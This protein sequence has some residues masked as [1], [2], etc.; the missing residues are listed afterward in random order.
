MFQLLT[1]GKHFQLG[2]VLIGLNISLGIGCYTESF[3]E[4]DKSVNYSEN[5]CRVAFFFRV[6]CIPVFLPFPV[7]LP[8]HSKI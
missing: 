7:F 1:L 6:W 3:P 2:F 4:R 5:E 8:K